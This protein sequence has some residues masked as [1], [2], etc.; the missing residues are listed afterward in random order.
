MEKKGGGE[1]ERIARIIKS[2]NFLWGKKKKKL[3]QPIYLLTDSWI[4]KVWD[5]YKM[6]CNQTEN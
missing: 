4:K 3:S 2:W 6:K 1:T 5:L